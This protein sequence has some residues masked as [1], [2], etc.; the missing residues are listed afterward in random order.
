MLALHCGLGNGGM[1]KGMVKTLGDGWTVVA[2][3]LP[4]HGRSAPFRAG[5]DVHDQATAAVRPLLEPGMHLVGHSF[6][7]TVALRL[8]LE[9]PE[10]IASL[11]LIE[12]VFFA[13]AK[14]KPGFAEHRAREEAFF[15]VY[16]TGD[17]RAAARSFNRIW[18][19]GTAWDKFPEAVKDNMA[20]GMPFVAGTEQSL[21]QDIHA[22]LVPGR[23]EALDCPV[24]LI[25][26]EMT[27]PIIEQVH[28]GLMARLP[29]ARDVV[30][31][32][33]GHMLVLT[34]PED[35]AEAISVR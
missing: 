18:G 8:A 3:D 23:L 27:V 35:V 24:T 13:A 34:H 28:A 4:G 31:P 30:V 21:W 5:P 6:G 19:G 9:A 14:G 10:R 32:G 2:P 25:R 22:M 26:G 20:E 17:L 29:A 12:P 15:D 16:A 11:S 33:A 1:W 7:A